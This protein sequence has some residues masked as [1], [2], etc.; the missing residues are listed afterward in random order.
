MMKKVIFAFA[1][2]VLGGLLSAQVSVNP[3]DVFYKEAQGWELKGYTSD[4]P[5][6]RPYPAN[7]IEEILSDVIENGGERDSELARQEYERIFSKKYTVRAQAD[8]TAKRSEKRM[9]DEDDKTVKKTSTSKNV[10]GEF[11]IGGDISFHPIVSFGYDFGWYAEKNDFDEYAPYATNK[12][13]DS[14]FDPSELGPLDLYLDWNT[15]VSVGTTSLYG[16]AGVNRVGFGPFIGDG[17]ALNDTCFHSANLAFNVQKGKW[18][19]ASVYEIIGSTHNIKDIDSDW[20]SGNKFLAFHALKYNFSKHFALTYYEN[21]VWGPHANIAY[22]FPAPYMT[23]QNIGGANDNLQMGVL[24]EVKPFSNFNWATDL[25]IDDM[26]VNEVFKGNFDTKLRFAAQTGFIFTPPESACREVSLNYTIV[27]PYTY[28]HWEYDD[29]RSASISGTSWNY[30]NY[31]NGGI[32]IGSALEPNSDKV[33]LNVSFRPVHSLQIGFNSS[34]IRHANS[35]EAFDDTDAARY[36]LAKAGTYVTDGSLYMHQMLSKPD[37]SH[38]EKVNAAWKKLGFMTSDHKMYVCQLGLSGEYALPKTKVGQLSLKAGYTFEY[39]HN[40]GVNTSIYKGGTNLVAPTMN[41]DGT[42]N[43]GNSADT[44]V[45]RTVD[46]C[47]STPYYKDAVE[48]AK[49]AWVDALYDRVNHYFTVGV[50]YTY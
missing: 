10:T 3:N 37:S 27:M 29:S 25:F 34:F 24:F 47:Y 39:I 4:L 17:L 38:G 12:M 9:K 21:I 48:A 30:Q 5:M 28:A 50:K 22:L 42:W 6:L 32:N 26:E 43:S 36:M 40:Y 11:A 44:N 23:I 15:N 35:A 14:I 16:T 46:E 31:T 33:S 41:A 1:A 49:K 7:K 45:Y 2:A 18:A 19:F 20:L 8:F 13:A